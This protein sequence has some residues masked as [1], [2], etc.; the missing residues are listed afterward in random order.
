MN[1]LEAVRA[2]CLVAE[3]KSFTRAAKQMQLSTTMVS[4][5]VKQLEQNLGCLLLKRNTRKVCL[6]DAGQNYVLQM[7]PLLNKFNE[8]DEEISGLSQ[9]PSGKLAISASIEFGCQYLT[10]LISQYQHAFP[11]VKLDIV[12]SNTPV[13]LFDSQIDLAFRVAPSLPDASHIAQTVC[14]SSLSL[15]ASPAYLKIH[16]T[17]TDIAALSEHRLLFFSHHIR[18][19]QWIFLLDGQHVCRKFNWAMTSNNGRF[20]NE[21]AAAGDGI[22]QAPR[23]SVA[24]FIKSGELVEVLAQHTLNPLTIAAVYPHRYALSNRVK[25]FVELAKLYFSQHPIP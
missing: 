18:H 1:K 5:H 8:V 23:Y 3:Y 15:W 7:K 24:P 13:D 14:H 9:A 20:L 10:P 17:P 21:A 22:I 25:S 19:D 2:L 16:G 6:T 11:D 4:R 12:L